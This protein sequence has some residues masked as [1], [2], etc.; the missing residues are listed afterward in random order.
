MLLKVFKSSF[1]TC[2]Q[3]PFPFLFP[4]P[5]S[6]PY[7][8]SLFPIQFTFPSPPSPFTSKRGRAGEVEG[9]I[10]KNRERGARGKGED[11]RKKKVKGVKERE[12]TGRRREAERTYLIFFP[13]KEGLGMEGGREA[14]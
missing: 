5:L 2:L 7:F 11:K 4:D 10:R 14:E 1:F 3:L 6:L 12:G 9:N 13:V 8:T